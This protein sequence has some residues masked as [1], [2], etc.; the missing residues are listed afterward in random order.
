[1]RK[2]T[3]VACKVELYCEAKNLS[4]IRGRLFIFSSNEARPHLL[5]DIMLERNEE[6]VLVRSDHEFSWGSPDTKLL[7]KHSEQVASSFH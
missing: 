6:A 3:K 5:A 4:E 1:M 2:V 7:L